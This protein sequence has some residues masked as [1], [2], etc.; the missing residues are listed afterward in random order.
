[1]SDNDQGKIARL[2]AVFTELLQV[3][4]SRSLERVEDSLGR[5]RSG[6]LGP[7][8]AHAEV[9]KH[10]ARAE[11]MA[12]RIARAGSGEAGPVLRDA[13]DANL[14]DR[15]EF[16]ELTGQ[17]PEAVAPSSDLGDGLTLPDK[18]DF[19]RQLLEEGP[20]LVHVDARAKGVSVPLHLQRDPKLVLRF[21][22]GLQPAI[23]DLT[24][25]DRAMSG[26]LTFGG[27]PHCCVLPWSA[28]YAVVSES[29]EQRGMVWP[30]DVPESVLDELAPQGVFSGSEPRPARAEYTPAQPPPKQST[31]ARRRA[32]HLKLVD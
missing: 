15:K 31:S 5:W 2:Q 13:Y 29:E 14:I 1:M 17:V 28:V 30:K 25:D 27:V 12:K 10:A 8:E 6:E 22:Y 21:G 20:V 32:S 7:F 16:I 3:Q 26:T 18:R 9:L 23:H 11:R 19:V 4:L 24:L